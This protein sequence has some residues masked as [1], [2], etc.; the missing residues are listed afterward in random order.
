[1]QFLK[2]TLSNYLIR[3]YKEYLYLYKDKIFIA[4]LLMLLI[5]FCNALM[6]I[7]IKPTID[8]LFITHEKKYFILI[9]LIIIIVTLTKG[10]AEYFQN[11]FLKNVGQRLVSNMQMKMYENFIKSDLNTIQQYSSGKAMSKFTNDIILMRSA[12]IKCFEGISKHL[13]SIIFYIVIM[14]YTEP[15]ISLVILLIFPFAVYPIHL[16]GKKIENSVI[17]AQ[18]ELEVLTAQIQETLDYSL[19]VKSY[20]GEEF[21]IKR[22]NN[23]IEKTFNHYQTSIKFDSLS[24]PIIE[25]LGGIFL[26]LIIIYGAIMIENSDSTPGSVYSFI[27][28]FSAAYR[29]LKSI[30]SLN[31]YFREGVGASKRI[32]ALLDINLKNTELIE[33]IDLDNV[34]SIELKNVSF[35]K[36]GKKIID[37]IS[38]SIK[39]PAT[40]AIVGESG[41]GKTTLANIIAGFYPCSSGEILINEKNIELYSDKTLRRNMAYVTQNA[42][43][44]NIKI[45]EN[46][47]YADPN[48]N[49]DMIIKSAKLSLAHEFISSLPKKYDHVFKYNKTKFST[50]QL[51]RIS[52]ARVLYKNSSVT[53]FDEA[54][55]S[56]DHDMESKIKKNI[57]SNNKKINIFITHRVNSLQNFDKIIFIKN[58]TIVE[59]GT[60]EELINNKGEFFNSL[61]KA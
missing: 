20:L 15:Y 30:I 1:M 28:A 26:A 7:I 60:H 48:L 6:V 47:G 17:A 40:I 4:F 42:K 59:S 2:P 34:E 25:T 31:I 33:K 12:L 18:K 3:I 14:L 37:N 19:E 9:P 16:F 55:N 51:Q 50:G 29:P 23:V 5:A 56:I 21:E 54:T 11:Y 41:S 61:K 43:L 38:L 52:I 27:A 36:F 32:F 22:I 53:I 44:F 46:I 49:F 10:I 39:K 13:I 24:S 8:N 35:I 45:K 58:G 57:I